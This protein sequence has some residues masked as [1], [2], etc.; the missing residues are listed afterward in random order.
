MRSTAGGFVAFI[1]GFVVMLLVAVVALLGAGSSVPPFVP[2]PSVGTT[3][4]SATEV[5]AASTTAGGPASAPTAGGPANAAGSTTVH[6]V[7]KDFAI[8]LDTSTVKAGAVT[9]DISNQGPSPHNLGVVKDNGASKARGLTNQADLIKDSP[10]IDAG[11]TTQMY[12]RLRNE[13]SL[14][15]NATEI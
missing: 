11:K 6:A 5:P 8:S 4:A 15:G 13:P 9:F 12:T 2:P 10:T 7:E 1:L 14:T 3:S